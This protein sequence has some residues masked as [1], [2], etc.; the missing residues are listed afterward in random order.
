MSKNFEFKDLE[1]SLAQADEL[2]RQI[3]SDFLKDMD[4]DRCMQFEKHAQNLEKIKSE[5]K[6]KSGQEGEFKVNSG[7][8][9]VHEAIQE[10]VKAM[11]DLKNHHF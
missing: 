10:M 9:G 2:I 5:V 7:V 3:N 6:A 11:N 1:Q 4:E 8:E